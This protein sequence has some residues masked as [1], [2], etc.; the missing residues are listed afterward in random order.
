M[1]RRF[2]LLPLFESQILFINLILIAVHR[3]TQFKLIFLDGQMQVQE[4]FPSLLDTLFDFSD[5][6]GLLS[7]ELRYL[8]QSLPMKRIVSK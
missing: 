1:W 5:V 2:T 3:G 4:A 7:Y 8:D 6:L